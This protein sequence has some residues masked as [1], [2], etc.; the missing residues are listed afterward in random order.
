[1]KRSHNFSLSHS[2]AQVKK[3]CQTRLS[4]IMKEAD[5]VK[6][7][8]LAIYLVEQKNFLY[9]NENFETLLGSKMPKL[10]A[11]GWEYWLTNICPKERLLV[12]NRV[13][14]FLIDA[15]DGNPLVLRYHIL[16]SKG[17]SIYLQHEMVL[18]KKRGLLFTLN[19]FFD[20]S[21]KERI[22]HFL[23]DLSSN[24]WFKEQPKPISK[25]EKQVLHLI[26]DGYSSKEIA[27]TLFISNH[28]AIS[29]RKH[30]IEKFQVKNT[31]QLIKRASKIID[32]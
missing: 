20:I 27:D 12:K 8:I 21:G 26:A 17:E 2:A 30:L 29:H 4:D 28:T 5:G 25:R 24:L 18:H 6:N 15:Y 9:C 7:L 22:E 1:M 3:G 31:A 11:Q 13:G 32:L 16:N 10:Y 14:K 19:Y 23:G